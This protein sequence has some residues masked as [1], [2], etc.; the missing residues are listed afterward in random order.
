MS[1]LSEEGCQNELLKYIEVFGALFQK[2]CPFW[3]L[4]NAALNF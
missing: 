2:K 4:S 1:A 3:P